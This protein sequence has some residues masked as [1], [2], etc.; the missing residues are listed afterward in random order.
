MENQIPIFEGIIDSVKEYILKNDGK[1][2][3]VT[4]T[5]SYHKFLSEDYEHTYDFVALVFPEK[6]WIENIE[7]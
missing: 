7:L 3:L 2:W 4:K 5:T 1:E 6:I